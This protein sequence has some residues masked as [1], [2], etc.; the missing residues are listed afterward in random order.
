[1]EGPRPG[2]PPV[3]SA[4][5]PMHARCNLLTGPKSGAETSNRPRIIST[6][7]TLNGGKGMPD[8]GQ[9]LP[10]VL[11]TQSGSDRQRYLGHPG[12]HCWAGSWHRRQIDLDNAPVHRRFYLP[13]HAGCAI[14]RMTYCWRILDYQQMRLR[15]WAQEGI[16]SRGQQGGGDSVIS[17]ADVGRL[18]GSGLL[19]CSISHF[20]H[21]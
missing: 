1:M 4:A 7:R 15:L 20:H 17:T 11:L 3:L 12:S 14:R 18:P 13:F 10:C 21:R 19:R 6:D 16:V 9:I 2:I 5:Y 8:M